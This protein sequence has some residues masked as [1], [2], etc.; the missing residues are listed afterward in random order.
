[1]RR[2]SADVVG[3]LAKIELPNN[4]WPS[5]LAFL[6]KCSQSPNPEHREVRE[7]AGL[8]L[9]DGSPYRGLHERRE[10]LGVLSLVQGPFSVTAPT[11]TVRFAVCSSRCM[12]V[13]ATQVALV[14]F[15]SLAENVGH[16]ME[17]HFD[18]LHAIFLAG[19]QDAQPRVRLAALRAVG[20]LQELFIGHDDVPARPS[21]P[22]PPKTDTNCTARS[23]ASNNW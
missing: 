19:L 2:A 6:L 22:P 3:V 13:A 16:H 1:M 12:R 4:Q 11:L 14:M 17:T 21:H 5:L 9:H 15:C 7:L 23:D 8:F 18:T 20:A 10:R